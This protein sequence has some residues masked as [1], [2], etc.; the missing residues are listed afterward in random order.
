MEREVLKLL[1][2]LVVDEM[3]FIDRGWGQE[4]PEHL[5]KEYA[6]L[7]EAREWLEMKVNTLNEKEY[8]DY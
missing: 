3:V 1:I 6:Q 2:R 4:K 5:E 7:G 8:S